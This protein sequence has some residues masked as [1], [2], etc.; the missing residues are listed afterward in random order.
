M[1]DTLPTFEPTANISLRELQ[2][3]QKDTEQKLKQLAQEQKNLSATVAAQQKRLAKWLREQYVAGNEDRIKLLLSGDNPNRIN[4][5]LQL[6][7]YVSQAQAK[8]LGSLRKN[9]AKGQ[10]RSTD[11][12]LRQEAALLAKW[13]DDKRPAEGPNADPQAQRLHYMVQ[14]HLDMRYGKNAEKVLAALEKTGSKVARGMTS[15]F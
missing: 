15:I 7:S 10:E 12:E 11:A 9:L 1:T 8:L 2:E 6:M 14:K 4:R 5:D 13:R 3:E